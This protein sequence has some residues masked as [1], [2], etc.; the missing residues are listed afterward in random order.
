MEH[1][2]AHARCHHRRSKVLRCASTRSGGEA[3]PGIV[4]FTK[5]LFLQHRLKAHDPSLYTLLILLF[6]SACTKLFAT[7]GFSQLSF[8]PERIHYDV[9]LERIAHDPLISHVAETLLLLPQFN[10]SLI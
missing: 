7:I 2:A 4:T 10:R 9:F 5:L 6:N 1:P 3:G 8:S